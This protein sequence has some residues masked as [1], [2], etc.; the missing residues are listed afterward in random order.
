MENKDLLIK[1]LHYLNEREGTDFIEE[2]DNLWHYGPEIFTEDEK[3]SLILASKLA[4][5]EREKEQG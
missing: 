1:F 3:K 5:K 4:H 2:G